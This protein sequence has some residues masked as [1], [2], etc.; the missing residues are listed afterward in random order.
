M[1]MY[2]ELNIGIELEKDTPKEVLDTLRY[3]LGEIEE[4]D[5]VPDHPLFG[6]TRWAYMLR[7]GS[8]YFDR[9][10][11]SKL[12]I[13]K[14]YDMPPMYFLNVGC[15]LKNYHGEIEL[16]L[17]WII[18]YSHTYGFVGYTRYEEFSDP[19]LIYFKGGKVEYKGVM[20][21]CL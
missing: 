5:V 3:M 17:D 1:G 6:D 16:F 18:K 11:D 21:G 13:E 19:T 8:F 10:T 4:L 12:Y 14:L 15:N 7:S 20:E 2:T 9:Q